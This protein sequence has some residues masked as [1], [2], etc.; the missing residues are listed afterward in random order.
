MQ[1]KLA[2]EYFLSPWCKRGDLNGLE[3]MLDNIIGC[4]TTSEELSNHFTNAFRHAYSHGTIEL[5]SWLEVQFGKRNKEDSMK[6]LFAACGKGNLEVAQWLISTHFEV[7][8]LSGSEEL[9]KIAL[10]ERHLRVAKWLAE[11]LP[12]SSHSYRSIITVAFQSKSAKVIKWAITRYHKEITFDTSMLDFF[13]TFP[14]DCTFKFVQFLVLACHIP[15]E[16]LQAHEVLCWCAYVKTND[17]YEV[18]KWLIT[19]GYATF[20]TST[21]FTRICATNN[22]NLVKLIANHFFFDAEVVARGEP[23]FGGS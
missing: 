14:P 17:A 3:W 4:F 9:L 18:G 16:L 21:T 1:E 8:Q 5:V 22:Q 7:R 13:L 11:T 6:L 20:C 10:R 15:K 12:I 2:V 23:L 19:Q